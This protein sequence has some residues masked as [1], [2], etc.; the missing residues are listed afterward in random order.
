LRFELAPVAQDPALKQEL[1]ERAAPHLAAAARL[2]AGPPWLAL[3]SSSL[4]EKLGRRE[5]AARH[6]EEVY[7]VTQDEATK[8]DIARRIARLRSETYAEAL[9]A[10]NDAFAAEHRRHYPYVPPDLFMLLG[11]PIEREWSEWVASGFH[12]RAED[13][14][15]SGI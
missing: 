13:D 10:A 14:T 3:N 9:G 12:D 6:L 8:A 1:L 7:A 2:G 5:Q 11:P 4:L 15:P